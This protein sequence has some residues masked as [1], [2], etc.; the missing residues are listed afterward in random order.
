MKKSRLFS[1]PLVIA[2]TLSFL[3]ACNSTNNSNTAAQSTGSD[4]TEPFIG[5]WQADLGEDG[6]ITAEFTED[7]ELTT[8]LNDEA[9]ATFGYFTYG[10]Y[11]VALDSDGNAEVTHP[12]FSEDGKELS[13]YD[14]DGNLM[15]T[16]EKAD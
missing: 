16:Y 4:Y 1:I 13:Y 14:L 15:I 7:G 10:E 2:L 6:V 3:G 11:Y 9:Y 8:Y 5:E 12:E